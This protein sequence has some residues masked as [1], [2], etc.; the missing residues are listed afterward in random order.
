M[1]SYQKVPDARKARTSQDPMGI[2][3]A[4]ITHK[5]DGEP[6]DPY[7]EVRHAPHLPV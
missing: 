5:G 4:E 3:L 2:T 1:G 6:V 7:P